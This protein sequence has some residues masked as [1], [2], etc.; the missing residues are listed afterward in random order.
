M[1]G[2]RVIRLSDAPESSA[3]IHR[4]CGAASLRTAPYDVG[5]MGADAEALFLSLPLPF[6]REF[7]LAERDGSVVARLGASVSAYAPDRGAMGF[8]EYDRACEDD[9]LVLVEQAET[10]C[11]QR[12]AGYVLAP[13]CFHT[14]FP[15][16]YRTGPDDGLRLSW[17]P[18]NPPWYPGLLERAG[19]APDAQYESH[20]F[21]SI[22]ELAAKMRPGY[23]AC[24][25]AGYSF[26][27]LDDRAGLDD[28]IVRLHGLSNA[29]FA[30]AH[31]FE[32][33]SLPVF[34]LLYVAQ[35]R[36]RKTVGSFVAVGPQ[37]DDVGF[38]LCFEDEARYFVIKTLGVVDAHQGQWVS[39][40]LLHVA[41]QEASRLGY[42]RGVGALI[43]QG[44]RSQSASRRSS[45]GWRHEYT[46][47]RRQLLSP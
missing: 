10:W 31:R 27:P 21:R 45:V 5:L 39:H 29:V 12:G 7:W 33:I 24:R 3:F 32:P 37:G 1:T 34:Q 20:E 17:E 40:G 8:L 36:K 2:R 35:A 23:E 6:P 14:W 19:Y 47:Y 43:H 11:R 16:R 22:A 30:Q 28:E 41:A 44:N 38:I 46:L 18:A 26:R 25:S 42:E 15:Y 9:A 13:V 4:F